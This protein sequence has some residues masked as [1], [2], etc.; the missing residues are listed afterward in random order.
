MGPIRPMQPMGRVETQW[1][2]R[3]MGANMLLNMWNVFGRA[4]DV[5]VQIAML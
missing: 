1:E 5:I 3:S 2:P 4:V